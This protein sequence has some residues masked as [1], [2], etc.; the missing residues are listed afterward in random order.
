MHA[1]SRAVEPRLDPGSRRRFALVTAARYLLGD[2]DLLADWWERVEREAL[3]RGRA[4]GPR[5]PVRAIPR[6]KDGELPPE[7]FRALVDAMRTPF[8]IEG[9]A[10]D[11]DARRR[12]SPEFFAERYGSLPIALTTRREAPT[13]YEDY[14]RGTLADVV[15]DIRAVSPRGCY[16]ENI[17]RIF[18][19]NPELE[20]DLPVAKVLEYMGRRRHYGSQLFLGG[21]GTGTGYHCANANNFFLMLH[22]RKRWTFVHPDH[23]AWMRPC[24]SPQGLYVGSPVDHNRSDEEQEELVPTYNLVP[25][26]ET[27]LEPG[28]ALLNPPW[29]WHAVDNLTPSSIAVA[30]RW[31]APFFRRNPSPLFSLLQVLTPIQWKQFVVIALGG[32]IRDDIN[33]LKFAD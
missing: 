7:R 27:V 17:S 30:S 20:A 33:R 28:D 16:A 18:N 2:P 11:C 14:E 31:A 15:E 5:G 32:K 21:S 1:P 24:V 29:W 4:A 26:Y 6:F 19:E 8:V 12:W 13:A 10:R 23:S 25:R 9:F 22:G 3:E